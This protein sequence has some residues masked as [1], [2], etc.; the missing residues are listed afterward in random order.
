MTLKTPNMQKP[1]LSLYKL[2]GLPAILIMPRYR[3]TLSLSL[4]KIENYLKTEQKRITQKRRNGSGT[5]AL[6]L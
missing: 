2:N 1:A 6:T 4:I 3:W 5:K